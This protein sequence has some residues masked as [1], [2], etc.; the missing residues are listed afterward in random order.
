[1]SQAWKVA[2]IATDPATGKT[3][4]ATIARNAENFTACGV[5]ANAGL[6]A[7]HFFVGTL[8]YAHATTPDAWMT[9]ILGIWMAGSVF[10]TLGAAF[11]AYRHF[12]MRIS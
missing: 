10:F 1:M 8:M 11:L 7:W 5:E 3:A 12:V 6:G 9:A 2:R 4:L